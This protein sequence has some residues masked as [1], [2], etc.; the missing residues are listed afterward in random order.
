MPL[1]LPTTADRTTRI[2]DGE[3]PLPP[4]HDPVT[5]RM[6]DDSEQSPDGTMHSPTN[7]WGPVGGPDD[8]ALPFKNLR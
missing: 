5:S 8:A 1:P 7:K 3:R 2:S 6:P 4:P